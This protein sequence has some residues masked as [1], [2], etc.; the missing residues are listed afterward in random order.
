LVHLCAAL[1]IPWLP[2]TFLIPVRHGGL[3]HPDEPKRD[4]EWARRPAAALLE[5]NPELVLHHMHD[6]NQ[7]RLMIQRMTYFRVKRTRLGEAY[8]RFLAGTLPRGA[9]LFLVECG[10]SW[11]TVRVADRHVFQHGA[12]GGATAEEYYRGG[13]RVEEYL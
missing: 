6:A 10:L 4:L 9:T 8:R 13:P 2:Q 7:D 5:A 12:L 1:G 11:P 3:H